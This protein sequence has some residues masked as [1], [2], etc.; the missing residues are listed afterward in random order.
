M[1][2]ILG[3]LILALSVCSCVQKIEN[4]LTLTGAGVESFSA[5]SPQSIKV[6]AKLTLDNSSSGFSVDS[7]AAVIKIGGKPLIEG[8]SVTPVKVKGH[9]EG[10]YRLDIEGRCVPGASL[11]DFLAPSNNRPLSVDVTVWAST[12][13]G[14]VRYEK[15]YKDLYLNDFK[16]Q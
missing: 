11:M 2:R 8:E 6:T 7:V 12:L 16:L 10:V 5:R 9:V 15:E 3:T 4:G 14:L 1:K 13:F